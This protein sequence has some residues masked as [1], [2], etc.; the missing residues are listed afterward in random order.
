MVTK[1]VA[2][3]KDGA[4]NPI[5]SLKAVA[6]KKV[7]MTGKE[8]NSIKKDGGFELLPNMQGQLLLMEILWMVL[9]SKQLLL[10]LLM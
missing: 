10:L 3:T 6:A 7:I 8:L 5:I 1:G 4:A 2:S 9:L